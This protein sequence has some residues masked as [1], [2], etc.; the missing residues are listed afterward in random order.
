MEIDKNIFDPSL[1]SFADCHF[2]M[3]NAG[4]VP[5]SVQYPQA[6]NKVTMKQWIERFYELEEL[7]KVGKATWKGV[8]A[9]KEAIQTYL[10][11][12][13]QWKKEAEYGAPKF[14]SL[15]SFDSRGNAHLSAPGSDSQR[16]KTYFDDQ[17]NRI[18][19]AVNLVENVGTGKWKP[20][21]LRNANSE[22]TPDSL[23]K[24]IPGKNCYECP[25]KAC[26]HTETFKPDS[27]SSQASARA[28]MS[29]HMRRATLEP[30]VHL[31]LHTLE[32]G[33][34]DK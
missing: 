9:V 5:A 32:F 23:I 33:S 15:Y 3:E 19:F 30:E 18:P 26:G 24:E 12:R 17:G 7:Q 6:V 21:W 16:V 11:Q 4:N 2:L 22:P 8:E 34:S 14:P 28:R 20:S 29:K 31:E 25:V 10:D 1:L 13:E 27:R